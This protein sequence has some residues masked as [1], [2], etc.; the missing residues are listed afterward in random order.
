MRRHAWILPMTAAILTT[1]PTMA[2]AQSTQLAPAPDTAVA[3][4]EIRRLLRENYVVADKRAALDTVLEKGL[5]SGRYA[6][7]DPQE[8]SRRISDDLLAASNDKHLG[9][10]HDP[11]LAAQLSSRGQGDA[12]QDGAFWERL[13]QT[14]N[15]GVV[16]LEVLDGNVRSMRY[17]GFIWTGPDSARAIDDAMRFLKGGDA[18]I[19]D[20]TRNGGGSPEA[21]RYL[22][23]YFVDRAQPLVK[24]YM[25]TDAPTE[26]ASLASVPGE[27]IAGVPVYV[28][29]S[30]RTASAAEEFA[31][32]VK[33]LGFATLVGETTAGAAYRNELFPVPGGYVLSVSVGRPELPNGGNWEAVGVAP[34]I[35]VAPDKAS[36][37][38]RGLALGEI[39]AKASP[40]ERTA[41][42]WQSAAIAAQLDPK[43]LAQP[44]DDYA[45]RYGVRT[46]S[47]AGDRLMFQRDGGMQ[48][49]LIPLG[50]DVFAV[51]A[52]P[53]TRVRFVRDGSGIG[54]FE[55]QRADGSRT[56]QPRG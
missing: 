39:A 29:T 38:A 40:S 9:L 6:A 4:A 13:A 20:L 28:L 54:S 55:L 47:V 15:H 7:P 10:S 3:I 46:I 44:L 31:S 32:H 1:A 19:I 8:F 52:D 48:S 30:G 33:R 50:E 16:A 18:V 41:L 37:R 42:E 51:E 21:V 12:A 11:K 17:D 56:M 49:A 53:A 26:S 23:S 45:G 24:F 25:R 5:A 2:L 35:A 43:P 34:E 27:R 14:R 36:L 22:T